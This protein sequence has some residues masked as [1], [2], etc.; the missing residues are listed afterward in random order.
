MRPAFRYPGGKFYLSE[1]IAALFPSHTIFVEPYAGSAGLMLRKKKVPI[2]ILNDID[3]AVMNLWTMIRDHPKEL[4]SLISDLDYSEDQFLYS[5]ARSL[6][7]AGTTL[8]HHLYWAAH[9]MVLH[10]QSRSAMGKEFAK[11]GQGEL[12]LRGGLPDNENSW[13]TTPELIPKISNRIQDV[14]LTCRPAINILHAYRD[15]RQACLYIDPTYLACTRVAKDVYK[16]EMSAADHMHMLDTVRI[17][18]AAIYIS[19]Y[20]SDLYTELLPKSMGWSRIE[21]HVKN[22]SGQNKVKEDRIECVW[23]NR[24]LL[25]VR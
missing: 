18:K 4:I 10:R 19:G 23:S 1:R 11:P 7:P 17:S 8:T 13:R 16:H 21:F 22:S 20:P 3:D 15:D 24:P 6:A 9:T 2:E 5:K 12:R 25:S 14:I